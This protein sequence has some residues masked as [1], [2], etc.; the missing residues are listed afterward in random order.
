[1]SPH[2]KL[3]SLGSKFNY[4]EHMSVEPISKIRRGAFS[5]RAAGWTDHAVS[6]LRN[7]QLHMQE[8]V[9]KAI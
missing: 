5:V 4:K 9:A 2:A 7:P 1:M 8:V 6:P 3:D